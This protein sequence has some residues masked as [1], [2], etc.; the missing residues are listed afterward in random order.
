VT[1]GS[2]LKEKG[3]RRSLTQPEIALIVVSK[4]GVDINFVP[5]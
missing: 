4:A 3:E 2:R 5:W 1:I